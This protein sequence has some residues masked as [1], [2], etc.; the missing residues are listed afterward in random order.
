M[1]VENHS[2]QPL[3]VRPSFRRDVLTV[4]F[5]ASAY[6]GAHQIAYL[7]PD[8]EKVLMAVWPA[9]GI[10]LA[11]LLLNPRRLWPAILVGLFIAGNSANVLIGRPLFNSVG[12]MTANV[13]E[14]LACAWLITRWC[15]E[16]V[17]FSRVQE[18]A[19]LLLAATVVNACTA[20]IGACTAALAGISSFLS[21]W[22]TWC[23]AD[24]LGILVVTPLIVC[25]TPSRNSL[26]DLRRN[27]VIESGLFMTIWCAVAWLAFHEGMTHPTF[28]LKPYL[29][30]G[31]LA[32][33]ALRLG[34]RGVTLALAVLAVI[35]LSSSSV[36]RADPLVWGAIS[37][38]DHVLLLQVYLGC[39]A[40]AGLLIA[41]SYAESKAAEQE[42][43]KSKEKYR[44]LY[45]N[46]PDI[47]ISVDAESGRIV[48]CNDTCARITGYSKEEIAGRP[49]LSMYH[50]DCRGQVEKCFQVFLKTGEVSNEELRALCKNG[51]ILDVMLNA[52]AMRD[53]HGNILYSRSSWSDI[54]YRRKAEAALRESE[55]KFSVAFRFAPMPMTITSMEDGR[56]IEVNDTFVTAYGYRRSEVL[57]K[58][59]FEFGMWSDEDERSSWLQQVKR[60]G[61]VANYD[62]SVPT[63]DGRLRKGLLSTVT[64]H[65]QGKACLLSAFNDITERSSAEEALRESEQMLRSIVVATPVGLCFTENRIIKWANSAW[66]NM[67]GFTDESEYVGKPTRIMHPSDAQYV[68]ARQKAYN[69]LGQGAVGDAY[70]DFMRRDG[71]QFSGYLRS[72][73]FDPADPSKGTVSAI[74]DE[75]EIIQAEKARRESEERYKVLFED[76][77]DAVFITTID[78][79]FID[80][81][82]SFCDLSGYDRNELESSKVEQ[83]YADPA[84]RRVFQET[85]RKTGSLKDFSIQ[86]RKKDGTIFEALV[87]ASVRYSDKGEILGYQGIIRDVTEKKQLERQLL[88]AQKME[89]VGALAGGVAHDFNNILQVSLGYSEL[90]L[91]DEELPNR[92]RKDLKKVFESAR[93]GAELV[94]RLLTFSRKTE[95]KPQPLNVNRRITELREMLDRTIP[96]MIEIQLSLDEDIATINGD[97]TQIDQVIM[98]LAVNARDA[99]PDGGKLVIETANVMLDEEYTSMH[100]EAK[101]GH[102]VLLTVTDTGL[103]M[104]KDTLEHIFEPF[105]T[106]KG[107]G[108]G[109]GLGLAMV[110]GIVKN[111]GG[112]VSCYSEPGHGTTFKIYFPA[113][114]SEEEE[115]ETIELKMPQGGSET[116]LLVDDE[117]LIRDLGSRILLKAGYSVLTAN[118]GKEALEIYRKEQGRISLVILDLIMPEMGG[119]QCIQELLKIDSLVKVLLASG[120]SSARETEKTIES[121]SRGIV[122]KPYEM[123]GLLE[124]VRRALDA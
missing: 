70:T 39:T 118:N 98:N 110:H 45:E 38:T 67:F 14:S 13:F 79:I 105:Y 74:S 99:E 85:I 54:T 123:R 53:E 9:G 11:A 12:F 106:T 88:Q 5:V 87:T 43:R 65:L 120:Y 80:A 36:V 15:G 17:R 44:D 97:P 115:R 86:L 29:L 114:V 41:A 124:A 92:Y 63:K 96:K 68:R 56:L 119:K 100:L 51:T 28:F 31:L 91:G 84:D 10:G 122:R 111:H 22:Q 103:G 59:V 113:V 8:A 81:N 121:R 19:V 73:H 93:R 60:E 66:K 50:P 6:F 77:R 23:I 1:S 64:I 104:D 72:T 55:E 116:I 89:A 16:N 33:P 26:P 32:W 20:V 18:V 57:G 52:R 24:G 117:E 34:Q 112:H 109:T 47:L 2:E 48:Q 102:Y 42:L 27:N 82:K 90:I 71:S 78:G 83:M 107:V 75:T 46:S 49:V 7:F 4:A 25:W 61:H 62:F 94:Q 37:P 69:G 76:S 101:P 3:P 95:F 58:T 30:V 21:F 35:A 40:V 108:E